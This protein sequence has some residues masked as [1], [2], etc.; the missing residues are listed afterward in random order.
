MR[1]SLAA[2]LLGVVLPARA[3]ATVISWE[4]ADK[5]VGEEVTVEGRIV[6]LH[7]SPLSCLLAFEP[8]FNRFTGVIQAE[9]FDRFP[10]PEELER[11]YTGRRVRVRGTVRENDR[12]PE[13]VIAEPA[14]LALA[15]EPRKRAGDAARAAQA[16]AEVLERM[17]DVLERVEELMERMVTTQARIDAML[18]QL[19]QRAVE[20]AAAP[21]PAPAEPSWGEPQERP[22]YEALRTIKRGMARADVER[23]VGAPLW[24][25]QTVAGGV[26]WY[27]GDG[28]SISFNARGRAES[29]V[30]F[31]VP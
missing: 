19:E 13:I 5:H 29:L 25:D 7:C 12:K 16:Q 20:V 8:T 3:A 6:G 17:A 1:R 28:R 11:R 31:P 18:A 24:V 27:Y 23:L 10:S 2:L 9:A 22:R 26:T 21:P 30:G 4:E 14:D 15:D